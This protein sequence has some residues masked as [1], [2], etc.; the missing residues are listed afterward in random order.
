MTAVAGFSA[1][2]ALG[3]KAIA[4][5]VA[6]TIAGTVAGKAAVG[7]SRRC[8]RGISGG[9]VFG[10]AG[11]TLGAY[12]GVKVP[13][14]NAQTMT[15][16]RLLEK[17]GRVTMAITVVHICLIASWSLAMVYRVGPTFVLLILFGSVTDL[18]FCDPFGYSFLT[19]HKV[20]QI[21]ETV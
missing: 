1:S 16:R 9:G 15:E 11:G 7:V 19:Q 10:A 17:A 21:R 12:V 4:S 2:S 13:A 6:R 14:L 8:C 3:S 5:G 18:V 20:K